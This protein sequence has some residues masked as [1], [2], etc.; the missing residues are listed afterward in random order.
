[1]LDPVVNSLIFDFEAPL[2]VD[3]GAKPGYMDRAHDANLVGQR[4]ETLCRASCPFARELRCNVQR[5]L[6]TKFEKELEDVFSLARCLAS[7]GYIVSVRVALPG[8]GA[9]CFKSLRH[10]FLVVHGTGEFHGMEFIVEPSLRQHFAIPHP[11]PDYE[12]VLSRTP[13]V[14]VGGSCRLVP[15]I[16]LLCALMAD[17]FQREGLPLPPWRREAAMLSKWLPH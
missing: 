16:Q 13:D 15:V 14:F 5:M 3:D 12:Y 11:S 17:S 6:L 10:M 2:P 8:T 1:M 4:L 9:D 7:L